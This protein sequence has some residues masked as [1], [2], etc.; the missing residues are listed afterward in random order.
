MPNRRSWS[1]VFAASRRNADVNGGRPIVKRVY[2]E[3]ASGELHIDTSWGG[4][5]DFKARFS[6]QQGQAAAGSS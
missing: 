5:V 1:A 2:I 6:R 4:T 3:Q